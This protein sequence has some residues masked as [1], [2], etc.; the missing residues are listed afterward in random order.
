MAYLGGALV[1]GMCAGLAMPAPRVWHRIWVKE[2]STHRVRLFMHMLIDVIWCYIISLDDWVECWWDEE[3]K[4]WRKSSLPGTMRECPTSL[5]TF[6]GCDGRVW[7]LLVASFGRIGF[8]LTFVRLWGHVPQPRGSHRVSPTTSQG[9]IR[10]RSRKHVG[11]RSRRLQDLLPVEFFGGHGHQCGH[12]CP[13][14]MA[15]ALVDAMFTGQVQKQ[16]CNME[17]LAEHCWTS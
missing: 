3:S 9:P 5:H 12:H 17:S 1:T 4:V 7:A 14:A 6:D 8:Q 11:H 10:N 2:S 16:G 15:A 13:S